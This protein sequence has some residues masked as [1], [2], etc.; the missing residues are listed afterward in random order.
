MQMDSVVLSG[1]EAIVL[2]DPKLT[3]QQ[4]DQ[5]EQLL[6]EHQQGGLNRLEE[7]LK[8]QYIMTRK[9]FDDL[10]TGRMTLEEMFET[11]MPGM[12]GKMPKQLP[13]QPAAAN[14]DA[15]IP[16]IKSSF[17][18]AIKEASGPYQLRER[19]DVA[20]MIAAAKAAQESGQGMEAQLTG[21]TTMMTASLGA[22]QDAEFRAR[23]HLAGTQMLVAFKKYQ[24]AHGELPKSLDDAAAESELKKVPLDP[25]SGQPLKYAL[26]DNKPTIYSVGKDLQDDG[27]Q[28]DWR[29]STQPG[30]FL[31][32]LTAPTAAK[33]ATTPAAPKTAKGKSKANPAPPV[34]AAKAPLPSAAVETPAATEPEFRTWTSTAGTTIEAELKAVEGKTA[35]LKKRDGTEIRVPVGKLSKF[36]QQWIKNNT[37]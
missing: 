8:V 18:A 33:A 28:V 10:Q 26:V 16:T 7:G 29:S 2:R 20:K 27:G 15:V 35:V 13:N 11:L 12:K 30:D 31:F 4:C 25:Y 22:M 32:V 6:I 37:P 9:L 24:L 23:A 21:M 34:V 19:P 3:P 5:I 36:D 1:I 17:T 14:F